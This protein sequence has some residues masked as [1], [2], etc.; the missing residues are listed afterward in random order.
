MI[1]IQKVFDKNTKILSLKYEK[2]ISQI[3]DLIKRKKLMT[4]SID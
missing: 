4:K 1:L 3:H 2:F